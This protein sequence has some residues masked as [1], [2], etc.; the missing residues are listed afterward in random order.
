MTGNT[1]IRLRAKGERLS[2]S[3]EKVSIFLER[4]LLLFRFKPIFDRWWR[5]LE[6]GQSFDESFAFRSDYTHVGL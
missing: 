3:V 5:L 2:I 6:N 1:R 4:Y